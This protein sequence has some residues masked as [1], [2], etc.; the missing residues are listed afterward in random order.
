MTS[1]CARADIAPESGC[2][3]LRRSCKAGG[4]SPAVSARPGPRLPSV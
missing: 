4:G 3:P 2:G 1:F